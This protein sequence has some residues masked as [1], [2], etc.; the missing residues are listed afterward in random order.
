MRIQRFLS[1]H[2]IFALTLCSMVGTQLLIASTN[3]ALAAGAETNPLANARIN[4]FSEGKKAIDEKRWDA[5]IESF[6]KVVAKDSKNA[7]AYNFLGLAYRWQNRLEESLKAYR[8]A[9]SLDPKHLGAN[10]YLGQAYLKQG[11]KAL[12]EAQLTKLKEICATCKE[13][14]SLA[15]ALAANN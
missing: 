8:V 5:A 14:E 2:K 15:S 1:A 6:N 7:D 3:P 11:E 4:D 10:E 9:L 13:T 12:A